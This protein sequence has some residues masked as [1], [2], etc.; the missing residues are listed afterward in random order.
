MAPA[1]QLARAGYDVW[2]GNQRGSKYSRKHKTLNP[3][4]NGGE[5]WH[6]S[7]VEMG[8]QDA[9]AQIDYIRKVT[10]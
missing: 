7:F 2:I 9:P 6:F 1:F 8:D 4:E 10:G 3:D 5:F